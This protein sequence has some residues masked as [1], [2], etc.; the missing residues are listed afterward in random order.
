MHCDSVSASLSL[1]SVGLFC[2]LRFLMKLRR[3]AGFKFVQLFSCCVGRSDD[4][5]VPYILDWKLKSLY[6][7]CFLIL[8]V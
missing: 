5:Q 8:C 2:D 6:K 1:Q 3:A 4:F 7:F